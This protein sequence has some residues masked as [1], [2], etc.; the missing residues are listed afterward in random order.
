MNNANKVGNGFEIN[1]CN[2]NLM[3]LLRA[4]RM[5]TEKDQN[6]THIIQ[7]LI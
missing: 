5:W 1:R 4:A 2:T 6:F 7:E 3:A